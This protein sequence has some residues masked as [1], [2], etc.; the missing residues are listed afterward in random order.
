[1]DAPVTHNLTIYQGRD[2]R[3]YIGLRNDDDTPID[4]SLRT[5]KAQIR[6]AKSLSS[7]LIAEFTIDDE[8][9]ADGDLYLIL[10][11]SQTKAITDLDGWWDYATKDANGVDE[12]YVAGKV[13]FEGSATDND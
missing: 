9:A 12:S 1:M 7:R 2:F 4:L 3:F 10:N 5:N 8:L 13:T 11:D 6:A